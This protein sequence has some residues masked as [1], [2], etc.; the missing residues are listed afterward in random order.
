MGLLD[1]FLKKNHNRTPLFS[2]SGGDGMS[3]SAAV[4]INAASSMVGIG[5]EYA[6]LRNRFGERGKDWESKMHAHG[7]RDNG[8][9][10]EFHE[11]RLSDGSTQT[12][13]FEISSFYGK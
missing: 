7:S 5:A 13:Y 8:K 1:F 6:W 11:I 9:I 3:E 12:I 4:V 2:Y 10:I